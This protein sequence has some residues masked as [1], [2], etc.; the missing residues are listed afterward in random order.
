M[1]RVARRLWDRAGQSELVSDEAAWLVIA[2]V[3]LIGVF[4]FLWNNI[5]D[6]AVAILVVG[7]SILVLRNRALLQPPLLLGLAWMLFVALSAAY[8]AWWG[9]PG[10][11][12]RGWPKHIPIALGPLVAVSLLA[13]CRQLRI[14][15]DRLVALLLAG[16]LLGGLVLLVRNDAIGS[17]LESRPSDGALGDLNRNLATLCCGLCIIST[18]SLMHYF[19]F[20]PAVRSRL[21]VAAALALAPLLIALFDLLVLLRG[22]GGY[23]ATA[24]A[25]T[26]WLFALAV[27][28]WYR[29]RAERTKQLWLGAAVIGTGAVLFGAYQALVISGRSVVKGSLGETLEILGQ[30]IVGTV[31]SSYPPLQTAEERLQLAAVGIDLVRQRPVLGWGPD[32]WLLPSLYSPFPGVQ[33]VNQFHDGYL[34]FLVNF[35]LLGAVLMLALLLVLLRA[36]LRNKPAGGAAMSPA[37]F[38]GSIALLVLLLV[39]NVTESVLHVKCAASIAMMLAAFACMRPSAA[40]PGAVGAPEPSPNRPAATPR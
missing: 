29:Q 18:I 8:A 34:Q 20:D 33:G 3:P 36:A 27:P 26:A 25:L 9:S 17:I 32:V 21:S 7:S 31:N 24:L 30:L 1:F 4:S 38:A 37:L 35:G 5:A 19:L 40:P 15:T 23:V 22:R 6:V 13:A 28:A 39:V 12:F 11:Q 2:C 16:V 14:P 10:N